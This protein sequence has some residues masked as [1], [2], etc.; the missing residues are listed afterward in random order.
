M[1]VQEGGDYL[2]PLNN[3]KQGEYI[4]EIEHTDNKPK[5]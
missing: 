3:E 2:L 4:V 1:T 5:K